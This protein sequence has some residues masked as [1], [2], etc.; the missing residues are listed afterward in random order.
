MDNDVELSKLFWQ[1]F[2]FWREEKFGMCQWFPTLSG[3]DIMQDDKF[4]AYKTNIPEKY[5]V[6]QEYII[7]SPWEKLVTMVT[8]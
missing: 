3:I 5:Y 4:I 2:L 1:N 7:G 8:Q 6:L